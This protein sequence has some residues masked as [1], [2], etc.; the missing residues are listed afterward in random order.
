MYAILIT[1]GPHVYG[2][3]GCAHIHYQPQLPGSGAGQR[4]TP[5]RTATS[6]AYLNRI[7]R[8]TVSVPF[9]EPSHSTRRRACSSSLTSQSIVLFTESMTIL[10]PSR[11]SAIGPPRRASGTTWPA[12]FCQIN[13][14]ALPQQDRRTTAHARTDD[15][16]SGR[17]RKTPIGDK[18]GRASQPRT[19][20]RGRGALYPNKRQSRQRSKKGLPVIRPSRV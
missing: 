6:L 4:K 14:S 20:Q 19:D 10:S 16:A 12:F 13:T 3:F 7:P 8:F 5:P 18:R 17:P 9:P 15:E 1:V 2:L 11:T